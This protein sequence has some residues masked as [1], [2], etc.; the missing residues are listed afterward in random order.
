MIRRPPR[1]T[2]FPYTTL[3]RSAREPGSA[4]RS[5]GSSSSST[6]GGSGSRARWAKGRRSP[7]PYRRDHGRRADPDRRGQREEPEAGAGPAP[8]QR[9]SDRRGLHRGG[10]RASGQATPS[11]PRPHGPPAPRDERDHRARPVARRS[12]DAPH[13]RHR[14]HRLG[15]DARPAEDHGGWLR[16]LPVEADSGEGVPRGRPHDARPPMTASAKILVVDDTPHNV[17][18]LADL[19]TVK[20]YVVVTASSGA[21][22]LEKVEKE[23]PDLVLLDVVMPEMSGYEVCRKTRGSRATATLPVVMV[24]ALD[25]AQERVKGI[26]AGA[27]DF[28]SKPISQQ[29][30]LARVKSLLRIK[31]LHDELGEWSRTLEQ[32]VEAQEIGRA[33]V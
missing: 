15:D 27:D 20:G 17:K 13:S 21:Q 30:L 23:Q 6:A 4:W 24:T 28:L 18:L 5:R 3:F 12:R 11:R 7:S 10:R 22:A 32:R 19:L 25:P 26:E 8:V 9:V 29:E 14:S 16:R 33:H 31:V 1:S 2:L